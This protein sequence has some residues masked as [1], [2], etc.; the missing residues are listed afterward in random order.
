VPE[1]F[2]RLQGH[3]DR[4][5]FSCGKP[6]LDEFLRFYAV[7][8]EK[9]G[10]SRTFVSI[11]ASRVIA[12]YAISASV[13]A[14]QKAPLELVRRSPRYPIPAIRLA[15]LAVD[16]NYHGLGVGRDALFDAYDRV[17]RLADDLGV[18]VLEIDAIDD[19]ARAF[20]VRHGA[21]PFPESPLHLFVTLAHLRSAARAR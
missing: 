11:D 9:T 21:T 6:S 3:H 15:R 10:Y 12:Y 19:M 4:A 14:F 7:Q 5:S 2:V 17:L 13:I 18:R 20:Y 1:R 8:N 16:V